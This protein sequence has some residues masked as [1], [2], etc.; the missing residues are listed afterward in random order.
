MLSQGIPFSIIAGIQRRPG[1]KYK[2]N[3]TCQNTCLYDHVSLN[4]FY[5]YSNYKEM[6]RSKKEQEILKF[7]KIIIFKLVELIQRCALLGSAKILRKVLE[8]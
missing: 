3:K 2:Y 4:F 8:M 6:D 5:N 1:T 7:L